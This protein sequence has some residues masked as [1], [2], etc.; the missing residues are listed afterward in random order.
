ME[1]STEEHIDIFCPSMFLIEITPELKSKL[2]GGLA[3]RLILDIEVR[4]RKLWQ[5]PSGRLCPNLLLQTGR[6]FSF[7][8]SVCWNNLA[9]W[10]EWKAVLQFLCSDKTCFGK[11]AS[12][13]VRFR[14]QTN[15]HGNIWFRIVLAENFCENVNSSLQRRKSS[16]ENIHQLLSSLF[17]RLWWMTIVRSHER[18]FAETLICIESTTKKSS[19]PKLAFSFAWISF[20]SY[21]TNCCDLAAQ[22]II[23]V[24]RKY[25]CTASLALFPALFACGVSCVE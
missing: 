15:A 25:I 1:P 11:I 22:K 14:E 10:E 5:D 6:D 17:P 12:R 19:G 20:G 16:K 4:K 21:T 23:S 3:L 2:K 24:S 13:N 9:E 8:E 18:L 7:R